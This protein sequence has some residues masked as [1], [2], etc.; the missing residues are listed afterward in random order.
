VLN[1]GGGPLEVSIPWLLRDAGG[2]RVGG[3]RGSRPDAAGWDAKYPV[4]EDSGVDTALGDDGGD[5]S[6]LLA[7]PSGTRLEFA[8]KVEFWV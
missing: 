8:V 4:R 7:W 5:N 1:A 3:E 6:G 2:R